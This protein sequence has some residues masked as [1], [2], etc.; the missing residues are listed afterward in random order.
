MQK[1]RNYGLTIFNCTEGSVEIIML[2]IH[3]NIVSRQ[4]CTVKLYFLKGKVIQESKVHIFSSRMI[5]VA[6]HTRYNISVIRE[7]PVPGN[8]DNNDGNS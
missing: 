7:S 4:A 1:M 5:A 8:E 3:G 6:W 2:I